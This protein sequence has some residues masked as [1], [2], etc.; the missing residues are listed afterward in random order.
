MSALQLFKCIKQLFYSYDMD[1]HFQNL[2]LF[3]MYG[4]FF[5]I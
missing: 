3:E 4:Q 1:N 2:F 5:M